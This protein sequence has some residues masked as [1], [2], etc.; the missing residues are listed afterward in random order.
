MEFLNHANG[1]VIKSMTAQEI[2][3]W[4]VEGVN[5]YATPKVLRRINKRLRRMG[6]LNYGHVTIDR[7]TLMAIDIVIEECHLMNEVDAFLEDMYIMGMLE[8][9]DDDDDE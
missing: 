7:V 9:P 6:L 5:V 1:Q 3:L 8:E 2:A 4:V